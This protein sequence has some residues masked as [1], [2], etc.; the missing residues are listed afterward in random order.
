MLIHINTSIGSQCG[1]VGR[2]GT[3]KRWGTKWKITKSWNTVS[4]GIDA[5][6]M[7]LV[8]VI[9]DCYRARSFNILGPN[10]RQFAYCFSTMS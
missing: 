1:R 7:K 3:L 6:F 2:D 10:Y 8:F 9:V 5:G 4:K